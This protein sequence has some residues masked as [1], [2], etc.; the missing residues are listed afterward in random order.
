[1]QDYT[2]ERMIKQENFIQLPGG[3]WFDLSNAVVWVEWKA[4]EPDR[5][6]TL[7]KVGAKPTIIGHIW[8]GCSDERDSGP[9]Q[10]IHEWRIIPES[11]LWQ[12]VKILP[13][14]P[15]RFLKPED[16]IK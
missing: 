5:K 12:F 14:I 6:N 15:V 3:K 13:E 10:W 7:Y 16:E 11:E 1:M 8:R 2:K 9:T 4:N